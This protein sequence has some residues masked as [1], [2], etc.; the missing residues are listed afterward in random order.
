MGYLHSVRLFLLSTELMGGEHY[1]QVIYIAKSVRESLQP[2]MIVHL[3]SC[4]VVDVKFV[5]IT[6][7]IL[8]SNT[9]QTLVTLRSYL[10][11]F[12]T[13]LLT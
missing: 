5:V 6:N 8:W 12:M 1:S 4:C 7:V 13:F 2:Q 9:K 10:S 11:F 3:V